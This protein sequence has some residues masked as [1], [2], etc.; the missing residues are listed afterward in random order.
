MPNVLELARPSS[1]PSRR[2][3]RD[4]ERLLR[5]DQDLAKLTEEE[6]DRAAVNFFRHLP[7]RAS[8]FHFP[9]T[10]PHRELRAAA[11]WNTCAAVLHVSCGSHFHICFRDPGP[12]ARVIVATPVTTATVLNTCFVPCGLMEC[13]WAYV[14][15]SHRMYVSCVS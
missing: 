9:T 11:A 15:F 13:V 4:Y 6:L 14:S 5:P 8:S 12:L 7:H 2:R 10:V 1:R 3:D